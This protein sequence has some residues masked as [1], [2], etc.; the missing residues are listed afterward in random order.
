[1]KPVK[2]SRSAPPPARTEGYSWPELYPLV[3]TC[4]RSGIS[5]LLRGHPGVGKSALAASLADDFGLPLV[6]IRLAQRDPADLCGVWFPDR[7]TKQLSVYPPSWAVEA[8]KRPCLLFLDEIN[9]AV[10]KLHQAAAY[11]IVLERRV[12]ELRLHPETVVLA[13]GNL[14]EDEAI[15]T[16][17]S[18]ALSNRFAHFIMRVDADAW[19]SWAREVGLEASICAYVERHGA[20]VLY[21]PAGGEPAFPTPRSWEMASRLLLASDEGAHRRL[22][23]AC[24]GLS[25]SERFFAWRRIYEH[26]KVERLLQQGQKMDFRTGKSAEP[27]FAYAVTYAVGA[28]LAGGGELTDAQLP[29]VTKFL[30]SPGLD[31]EYGFLCLRQLRRNSDLFLRLR[32]LPEFRAFA[33]EVVALQPSIRDFSHAN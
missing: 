31:I 23:A 9:A 1:M 5:V 27:S 13:A 3:T 17:L 24:I 11:Q 10:T 6:D 19:L 15:V 29:N 32:V 8:S 18:S 28:W 25:A 22:V 14:E 12:G 21:A 20:E 30:R 2:A 33:A 4:L 16:P 7:E 26:V